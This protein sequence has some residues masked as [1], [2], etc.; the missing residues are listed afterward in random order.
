MYARFTKKMEI[1]QNIARKFSF[2]Q[3]SF[4]IAFGGGLTA[5]FAAIVYIEQTNQKRFANAM[6]RV[7][8]PLFFC[9]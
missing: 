8:F 5:T 9:F 1:L 7:F 4:L 3:R 2:R 6:V